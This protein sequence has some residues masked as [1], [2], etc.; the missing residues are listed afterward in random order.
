MPDFSEMFIPNKGRPVEYR[1]RTIQMFDKFPVEN[2]R[3]I[4]VAF[5]SVGSEWLQG[6]GLRVDGALTERSK[7]WG[8]A[9]AIWERTS[10]QGCDLQITTRC[11]YLEVKNLWDRGDGRVEFWNMGGA[12]IVESVPGGRRYLCNDGAPDD[13]FDDLIFTIVILDD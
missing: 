5:E 12:M 1:G 2:G 9:L 4:R 7:N 3:T 13:D 11:G 10:P 8:K 6:I